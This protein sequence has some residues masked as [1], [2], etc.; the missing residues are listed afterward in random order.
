M[1]AHATHKEHVDL[2]IRIFARDISVAGYPVE[3]TLGGQQ[4]FSRGVLAADV[5][6]WTSS[7]VPTKD[8]QKLFDTLFADA[9]LRAAW[10]EAHGQAPRRD[11]RVR[12]DAAA[13]GSPY[14]P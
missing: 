1:T 8:G 5:L 12:I 4:E 7:G 6:P 13:R 11:R 9:N 14:L 10:A 2:E 3:I